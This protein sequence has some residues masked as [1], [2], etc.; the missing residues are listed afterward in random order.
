MFYL[1]IVIIGAGAIGAYFGSRLHEAGQN[2][3]FL[4]RPNRAKQLKEKGLHIT[5]THGNYT[6]DKPAIFEN[7]EDIENPDL[8]ILSV[9][10][11]HLEGT[12]SALNVLV[13]K[14]AKILPLLNGWEHFSILQKQFGEEAVIGAYAYIITTLNEDGHVIQKGKGHDIVFGPLHPS[15]EAICAKLEEA[16]EKANMIGRKSDN[17][18]LEIWNKYMFITAFSGVTTATNLSIGSIREVPATNTLLHNVLNEMKALANAYKIDLT[19]AHVEKA[20]ANLNALAP[21]ATSSMHQDRRKGFTLEVEHLQGGALRLS[22]AVGLKLPV[23]ETLYAIIK[24]F[25]NK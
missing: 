9:K 22:E 25:E 18:L 3:S 23:I 11:Y 20:I 12:L 14:G 16:S 10:G 19:D 8:V 2:V 24:P 21:D 15:H 1:N 17:I 4:V 7:V 6:F 5:S 13:K